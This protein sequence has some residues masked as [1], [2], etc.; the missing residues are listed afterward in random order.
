MHLIKEYQ[1]PTLKLPERRS[2]FPI[3]SER[4]IREMRCRKRKTKRILFE[5]AKAVSKK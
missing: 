3:F 5:K 1:M 4:E 2:I